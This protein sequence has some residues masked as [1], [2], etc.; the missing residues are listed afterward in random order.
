MRSR[1]EIGVLIPTL[2]FD[3]STRK[4]VA[5]VLADRSAG[6]VIVSLVLDGPS[7][8]PTPDWVK[9]DG[10]T[11]QFTGKRSGTATAL[12]LA[13]SVV[14]TPVLARLDADDI[15]YP[16]RFKAQL[17]AI[18]RGFVTVGT[19]GLLIDGSER[20]IGRMITRHEDKDPRVA[21]LHNNPFIH[22]STLFR[23]DAFDR[24]GGYDPACIRMQDYDLFLRLALEGPMRIIEDRLVGYRLHEGQSSKKMTGFTSL[25]RKISAGRSRL[26]S[27]LG[28]PWYVQTSRNA[29]FVASQA[30]RYA[31]LRRPGYLRGLGS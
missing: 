14:D 18:D 6:P 15:S 1:A 9:Q 19:Q 7:T 12:N 25:M 29:F 16:G 23:S 10:V 4:A 21:L 11:L 3:D 17:E 2:A 24:A 28:V 26:A 27:D 5:S 30:S 8:T 31:G 22:S 20:T 13:R